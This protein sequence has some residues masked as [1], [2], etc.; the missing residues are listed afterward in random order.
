[1]DNPLVSYRDKADQGL[2]NMKRLSSSFCRRWCR[3]LFIIINQTYKWKELSNLCRLNI[4]LPARSCLQSV[5]MTN[6]LNG[7]PGAIVPR[8]TSMFSGHP[9]PHAVLW[10]RAG[11]LI[12]KSEYNWQKKVISLNRIFTKFI[13]IYFWVKS[14]KQM[15][16]EKILY[17]LHP[18][19]S[20]EVFPD[21]EMFAQME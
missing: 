3:S 2:R 12:G 6:N 19:L 15:F 4:K 14:W 17:F 21:H 9:H 11:W 7:I 8:G 13:T 5:A 1:M 10:L 20:V 18:L 16:K